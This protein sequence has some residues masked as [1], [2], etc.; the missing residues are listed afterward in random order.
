[1]TLRKAL[2][3]TLRLM[4]DELHDATPDDLLLAALTDTRTR[5][6]PVAGRSTPRTV[7]DYKCASALASLLLARS[8]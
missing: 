5:I 6:V 1:M 3:R 7:F 2:D 8:P 4:R